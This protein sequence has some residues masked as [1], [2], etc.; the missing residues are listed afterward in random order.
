MSAHGPEAAAGGND[1]GTTGARQCALPLCAAHPCAA[2]SAETRKFPGGGD[3]DAFLG[4]KGS[5]VQIRPSRLVVEFF[6]KYLR[7]R[8]ASKSGVAGRPSRRAAGRRRR[9][10]PRVGVVPRRRRSRT[11]SS[12]VR[13][14][15]L[16]MAV[17]FN[18]AH[19]PAA[20]LPDLV[21]TLCRFGRASFELDLRHRWLQPVWQPPG[22]R[23]EQ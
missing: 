18:A 3:V 2:S 13:L 6:R 4:V 16:S 17:A 5:P 1:V 8:R 9:I 20:C 14:R 11:P 12:R 22:V 23:P 10:V 21:L 7:R 15:P 19:Q